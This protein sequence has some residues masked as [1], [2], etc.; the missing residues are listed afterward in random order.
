MLEDLPVT[1]DHW[2]ETLGLKLLSYQRQ[3]EDYY[4]FCLREFWDQLKWF[5]EELSSVS[6]LVVESLLKV[7][8]RKL[9]SS[10]GHIQHLFNRQLKQWEDV[11]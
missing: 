1:F 5:E 3:T 10:T 2:A 11:K 8:E 9:S 7:H 6:Q 4:N